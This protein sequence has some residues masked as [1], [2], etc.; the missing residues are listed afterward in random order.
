MWLPGFVLHISYVYSYNLPSLF[1]ICVRAKDL[2]YIF[3][4][5]LFI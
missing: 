3:Y 1:N 2:C 5:F 4:E